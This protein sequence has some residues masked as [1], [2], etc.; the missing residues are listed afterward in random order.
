[1]L[2]FTKSG[3]AS[4]EDTTQASHPLQCGG[5]QQIKSWPVHTPAIQ[6]GGLR[7]GGRAAGRRLGRRLPHAAPRP[8]LLTAPSQVAQTQRS[9]TAQLPAGPRASTHLQRPL[10]AASVRS[11]P[12]RPSSGPPQPAVGPHFRTPRAP[13]AS[14]RRL[15]ERRALDGLPLP[16]RREEKGSGREVTDRMEVERKGLEGKEGRRRGG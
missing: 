12:T 2:L 6:P 5:L 16:T 7:G 11:P 3:S 4:R 14:I 8:E 1:M 10:P 13:S 9:H 15:A